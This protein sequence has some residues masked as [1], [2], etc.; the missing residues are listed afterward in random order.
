MEVDFENDGL[1]EDLREHDVDFLDDFEQRRDVALGAHEQ[2][3]VGAGVGEDLGVAGKL[4]DLGD[5]FLG[6]VAVGGAGAGADEVLQG[7]RAR[8]VAAGGGAS[9]AGDVA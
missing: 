2:D 7:L 1:D 4:P 8:V 3:G 9:A 5:G 6:G